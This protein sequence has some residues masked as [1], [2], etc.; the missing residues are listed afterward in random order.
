MANATSKMAACCE[1]DEWLATSFKTWLM[2]SPKA[3]LRD[4]RE[5]GDG[6]G[7]RKRM[8]LGA[9]GE[10]IASRDCGRVF[11]SRP[12]KLSSLDVKGTLRYLRCGGRN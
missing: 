8:N 1:S 10:S 11:L 2:V 6:T 3:A 9:S 7:G 4:F 5:G 12:G